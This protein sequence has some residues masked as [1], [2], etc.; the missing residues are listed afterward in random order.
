MQR[1]WAEWLGVAAGGLYIPIEIYEVVRRV[2]WIR[3]GLL[4]VNVAIVVYLAL[5]LWQTRRQEE[6]P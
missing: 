2:T 4:A 6:N 5:V 3:F 1:R